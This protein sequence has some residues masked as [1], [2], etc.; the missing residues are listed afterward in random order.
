MGRD[1]KKYYLGDKNLPTGNAK[2]EY[3]TAQIR[4]L[5]GCAESIIQ[6]T[7]HFFI[8][9]LEHGKQKINLYRPQKRILKSLVKNRFNIILASRQVG[10]TTLMTIYAL[11]IACFQNDK[12]ILIV[13]NKED[14]SKEI[15]FRIKMAYE[16]LPNWLKPGVQEWA[17]TE[18]RFSNDSCIRISTTSSSAARGLSIN[19]VGGG[20]IV[21]LRDKQSKEVF[22]I[23]MKTLHEILK[24]DGEILPV[25]LID[26]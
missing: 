21:T 18:V 11:W 7:S 20:S 26:D 13:A 4:D 22:D 3:T 9:T 23:S 1:D 10:K 6:F 25:T 12:T 16:Q 2:L 5:L 17:K 15:L 8:T 19:C 24:R 14:T